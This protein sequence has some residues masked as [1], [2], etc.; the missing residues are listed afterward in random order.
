MKCLKHSEDFDGNDFNA[1][2]M[3]PIRMVGVNTEAFD[4]DFWNEHLVP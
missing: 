1:C 3:D 2:E 4:A